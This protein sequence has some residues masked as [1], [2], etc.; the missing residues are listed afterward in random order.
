MCWT[1]GNSDGESNVW[2]TYFQ[3]LPNKAGATRPQQILKLPGGSQSTNPNPLYEGPGGLGNIISLG[4]SG[5]MGVGYFPLPADSSKPWIEQQ[6]A[7]NVIK[8]P[9]SSN[10]C[11]VSAGS[12][13]GTKC[14]FTDLKSLPVSSVW[15]YDGINGA[16][17]AAEVGRGELMG[18]CSLLVPSAAIESLSTLFFLSTFGEV[19]SRHCAS[20]S[21]KISA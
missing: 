18:T 3:T 8:F 9:A 10:D 7:L 20:L 13:D 17:R 1:D 11:A 2:A 21:Q 12:H 15:N 5:W 19:I 4:A 14:T 16:C 6:L